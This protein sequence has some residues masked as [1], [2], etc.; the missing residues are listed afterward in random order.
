MIS[1]REE[2][3][4]HDGQMLAARLDRPEV[5]APLA[6]AIFAHCFTCSKDLLA[7]RRIAQRLVARGIAVLRFDFT[8]LG[9]SQGEFANTD[10]SSNVDDLVA[11]AAFLEQ[12]GQ[13]ATLLVGHS[14]GGAAVIA[15][16]EKLPGIKAIA[17]IGAPFEPAHVVHNL[18]SSVE[19][20]ERDGEAMVN[21]AGREFLIRRSFIEDLN[22]QQQTQRIAALKRPLLVM[23]APGDDVV[24]VS[25]AAQIF[26]AASH[27]RSFVSLDDADHLL[28]RAQ[29]AEYAA[30]VIAGWASRYLDLAVP[31]V[32]ASAPEGVTRTI[33]ADPEGFRQDIVTGPHHLLADEPLSYG[34]T[35]LGFTPYQL[36][37]ASLGA[38]TSMTVRGYAR[39]KKIPLEAV[40]VDVSHDKIHADDCADCENSN[41]KIDQFQRV[42]HFTGDLSEEQRAALLA[43]A[44]RCPVHKT[45]EANARVMTRL[46]EEGE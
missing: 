20:I 1:I 39:R 23:H 45:L 42:L 26:M 14:L 46:A 21:L 27:P 40:V 32:Q 8:G 43:I 35:D 10:F 16:A 34:G 7:A 36:L 33:E 11:A 2:F 15:A 31:K 28:T 12:R 13:K 22:K 5:G 6:V 9:H 44:D 29:D 38:C 17:T 24:E 4:G 25:N 37:S 18:G 19:A 30:D 3:A 41:G